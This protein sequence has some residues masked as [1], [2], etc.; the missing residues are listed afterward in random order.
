MKRYGLYW[1]R[2]L[3][4]GA[5]LNFLIVGHLMGNHKW[6][7]HHAAPLA[8]FVCVNLSFAADRLIFGRKPATKEKPPAPTY[9]AP[10]ACPICSDY[11]CACD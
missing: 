9:Y 5:G 6:K 2:A 7:F 8:A 10:H 3:T 1:L 11:P 4:L